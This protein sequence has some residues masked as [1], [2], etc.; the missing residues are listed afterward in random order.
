M[1]LVL[2]GQA[3]CLT[4]ISIETADLLADQFAEERL[5]KNII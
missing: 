2:I 4:I 3:S 5:L 1:I